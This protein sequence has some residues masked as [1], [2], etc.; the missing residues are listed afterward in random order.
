MGLTHFSL[1]TV[2]DLDA[3]QMSTHNIRF[4]KENQ[5]KKTQ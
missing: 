5:E 2:A 4:L 3:I 1:E